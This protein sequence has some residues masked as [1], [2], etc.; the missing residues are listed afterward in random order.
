MRRE[1]ETPMKE[2]IKKRK[3]R[4]GVMREEKVSSLRRKKKKKTK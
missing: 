1:V 2:R 4:I 3:K